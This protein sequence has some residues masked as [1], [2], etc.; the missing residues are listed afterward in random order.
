MTT[1]TLTTANTGA[2][3]DTGLAAILFAT[4]LGAGLLFAAGFANSAVMHDAAHDTRHSI[5]FPCH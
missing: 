3:A 4:L 5:G 2:R 1:K